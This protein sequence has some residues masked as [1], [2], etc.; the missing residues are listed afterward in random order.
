MGLPWDAYYV[1]TKANAALTNSK[2]HPN[3]GA[4]N[5]NITHLLSGLPIDQDLNMAAYDIS[6]VTDITML[7]N[8]TLPTTSAT[9][10]TI[11]VGGT[12]FIHFKGG[13]IFIGGN[14][15]NYT[16]TEG[17]HNVAIG[18]S[19]LYALTNGQFNFAIGN[20]SQRATEDGRYN[21]AIGAETLKNNVSSDYNTAIGGAALFWTTVGDNTAIGFNCLNKNSLGT[22]LMGI[23]NYALYDNTIGNGNT[24]SGKDAGRY[25]RTGSGN[26]FIGHS[27]GKGPARPTNKSGCVM[28]GYLAGRDE[29][30]SNK[31]Y[32]SNSETATPLIYGEFNATAANQV[33]KFNVPQINIVQSKTPASAAAAGTAGNI[34]WDA[35]YIYVCTAADTWKRTAIAPW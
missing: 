14:A 33:L 5:Y 18:G 8:L 17:V 21:T 32:I 15:G 7:G 3:S 23:G 31:L 35:N 13:G 20:D 9:E 1:L 6:N 26:V 22:E 10:G 30:G 4:P 28:I 24:G 11:K 16:T 2:V 29:V 12:P 19:A 34:C 25:N 27:A